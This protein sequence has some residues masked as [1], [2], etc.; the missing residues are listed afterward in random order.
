M[1]PLLAKLRVGCTLFSEACV[2]L[3][4]MVRFCQSQKGCAIGACIDLRDVI[5]VVGVG[6]TLQTAGV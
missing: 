6:N 3:L 4:S 2:R 1:S 5:S